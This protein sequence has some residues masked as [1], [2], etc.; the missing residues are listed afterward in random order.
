MNHITFALL[1]M[2]MTACL[3]TA[4]TKNWPAFR[5]ASA[6]G[7]GE[8]DTLPDTWS[9][10]ENVVWKADIPGWGWSSPIV[11]GDKVFITTAVSEKEV[12]KPYIGGYPGGHVHP[13]DEH[14][15][16]VYCLD[17]DTGDVVWQREA[18]KGIPPQQRHPKN[19]YA[20]ATPITDGQRIYAYFGNIGMF[21]YDMDG[22]K[23]WE[24]RLGSFQMRGGWGPGTSPV[25][26]KDRIFLVNDNEKESFMVALDKHTGEQLWRIERAERS[27]WSTPYVWENEKRTEIVTIGTN[28]MRSYGLDGKLLWELNGTSGLVS[29]T[30]L[31]KHGL[32]YTGAAYHYGPIYAIRPG[33]SGDISLK[34]G[35]STNEWIAWSHGRG[36]SIHPSFL[37]SGERMYVLFDARLLICYDAKTGEVI[38]SRQ[39]LDLGASRGRYYASPWAYNG[40]IFL[41]NEDGST[42]V[43]EDGSEFKVLGKNDLNDPAW[44]TPAIARGSLFIRTFSSLYRLQKDAG[45]KE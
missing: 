9:T 37:V 38:F 25:L 13:M 39:R 42:L 31:S 2:L 17:F 14:R 24:K 41:L 23:I 4:E 21:C 33:A 1:T 16:M 22:R 43:V 12:E 5:G 8:G 36:A 10:T 29:L 32:L 40:K 11:W 30:P 18:H 20:N 3:A 34:D 35:E 27:N 44:A 6:D 26:H 19:S 15:W 28:R 45:A 7:L